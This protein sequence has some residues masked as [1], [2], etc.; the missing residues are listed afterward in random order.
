MNS[1][2]YLS[3]SKSQLPTSTSPPCTHIVCIVDAL[4]TW[5]NEL[6]T[7]NMAVMNLVFGDEEDLITED[8][9]NLEGA[10][11]VSSNEIARFYNL[12]LKT[13][14]KFYLLMFKFL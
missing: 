12:N 6:R 2:R 5:Q 13:K 9:Y 14:W 4:R 7:N 8:E 10:L 1:N 11:Y 3:T